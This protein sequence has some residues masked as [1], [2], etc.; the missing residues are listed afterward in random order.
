MSK[1][2]PVKLNAMLNVTKTVCNILFPLITIPYASRVLQV[3]NYG[4]VNF[5]DSIIRFF[6][7]FASLG[8]ASYAQRE[9]PAFRDNQNKINM[10]TSEVF[11]VNLLS[12]ILSYLLLFLM[13]TFAVSLKD[14]VFV[15]LVQ[16][17]AIIITTIGA[18]WVNTI[19]EDYLYITVRYIIMQIL[20]LILLFVF[21]KSPEDYVIYALINVIASVGGNL[22]NILYI[23]KYV[24]IHLAPLSS[25]KKHIKP[26]L[27]LFAVN[28]AITVY[29]SSDITILGLFSGDKQVGIYTNSSRVYTVV[30]SILNAIM[31]VAIPR[32]SF[33]LGHSQREEYKAMLSEIFSYLI[34]LILP[35][36]AFIFMLSRPIVTILGGQA[37]SSGFASLSILSFS[38]IFSVLACFY[39]NGVLLLHKYDGTYLFATIFSA[40]INALLNFVFIPWLGMN[41]AAIT[42]VIAEFSM[43]FISWYVSRQIIKINYD[44]KVLI[45]SLI[46]SVVMCIGLFLMIKMI[47][48]YF[49]LMIISVISSFLIYLLSLLVLKHPLVGNIKEKISLSK[50]KKN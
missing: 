30:K 18:D 7:L 41:G 12:T 49:L 11:T 21:V 50:L 45:S 24:K 43:F 6:I 23:K 22:F 1:T 2:K 38:L 31:M 37:Y 34:T 14:Y 13:L 40:A 20:S 42:T 8:I 16:S 27:Q 29:I 25:C 19:Y 3:A 4:K 26:L 47:K 39:A 28:V 17:I 46:G 36:V 5:G 33:L 15:M 44:K 32:F 10:F 35:S 9:G 48:N